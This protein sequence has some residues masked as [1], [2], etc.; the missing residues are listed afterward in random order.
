MTDASQ[1]AIVVASTAPETAGGAGDGRTFI[2]TPDHLPNMIIQYVSPL[3]QIVVRAAKTYLNV[4]TG[5]LAAGAAGTMPQVLPSG[6]F[7]HLLAKC[8]G[9]AI[10]PAVMS[11]IINAGVLMSKLD[12]KFPTLQA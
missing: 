8:S 2:A 12:Q 4:L 10:A 5:L 3:V 6:D 9:L 11:V 7:F 1:P